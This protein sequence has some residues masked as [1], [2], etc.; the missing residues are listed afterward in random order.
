MQ[1]GRGSV[2]FGL[3]RLRFMY[4]MVRAV[5]GFGSSGLRG[6]GNGSE[7]SGSDGSGSVPGPSL[8]NVYHCTQK[9]YRTELSYFRII[10]GISCSVITEQACFWNYLLGLSKKCEQ[11]I[12]ESLTELFWEFYSVI[13]VEDLPN[14]NCLRINLVVFLCIMVIISVQTV[15]APPTTFGS[16]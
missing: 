4:G 8:M 9:S 13:W 5:P 6:K 10:F 14:R 12:T 16:C 3:V 1:G 2:R 7:G 11:R 15:L